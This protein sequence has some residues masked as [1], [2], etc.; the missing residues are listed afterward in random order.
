MVKKYTDEP[1]EKIPSRAEIVEKL[2][3]STRKLLEN[4]L[5]AKAAAPDDLSDKD[6][7]ELDA[8]IAKAEHM[9]ESIEK[10]QREQ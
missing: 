8:A 9:A 4:L 6:R 2:R 7:Q 3:A 10:V 1:E 5:A